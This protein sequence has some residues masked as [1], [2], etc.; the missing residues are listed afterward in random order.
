MNLLH[1]PGV[2]LFTNKINNK[3]YVGESIDISARFSEHKR[4][5]NRPKKYT[6]PLAQ[7][8]RKYGFENFTFE[9]LEYCNKE[10]RLIKEYNY[11]IEYNT[12]HKDGF[13]Y[14]VSFE[15]PNALP[16]TVCPL[17]MGRK[18]NRAKICMK[19]YEEGK[20][21]D[22]TLLKDNTKDN[23][24]DNVFTLFLGGGL[25]TDW[26]SKYID[27]IPNIKAFNPI[28]EKWDEAAQANE[29]LHRIHDDYLLFT[30]EGNNLVSLVELTDCSNKRPN[31]TLAV[32]DYEGIANE[33][34]RIKAFKNIEDIVNRNGVRIFYSHDDCIEYLRTEGAN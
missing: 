14:N 30:I 4:S 20:S 22:D 7:A 23:T 26:R 11:I 29:A 28:V 34:L 19:C 3:K 13:G 8:F 33:G 18:T 9:V 21:L 24:K 27:T 1:K 17:C 10:D 32:F 15:D 25:N 31:S 12:L 5:V 16:M 6:A 2:Y